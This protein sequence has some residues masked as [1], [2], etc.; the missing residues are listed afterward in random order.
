[1]TS[2]HLFLGI[3]PGKTGAFVTVD[4]DGELHYIA[5]MPLIGKDYDVDAMCSAIAAI[6]TD[7]VVACIEKSGAAAPGGV[8]QGGKAMF[9]F[10]EGYGMLQGILTALHVPFYRAHPRLWQAIVPDRGASKD[11]AERKARIV[12]AAK[13]RW[14]NI[15]IKL[16][17]H[18][19][20]ADAAWIAEYARL[21]HLQR[22]L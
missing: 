21:R 17:K 20:R 9:T 10:G 2:R 16:K 3:D 5:S 13:R 22:N 19:D 7:V 14:P 8:R 1:V 11:R 6:A 15:D 4:V 12:I 18:W